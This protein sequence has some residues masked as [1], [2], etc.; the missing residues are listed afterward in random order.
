MAADSLLLMCVALII[1]IAFG[2]SA[3]YPLILRL[4]SIRH[5]C[6][7]PKESESTRSPAG[8]TDQA[9][10]S[11]LQA[12]PNSAPSMVPRETPE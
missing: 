4:L 1:A 12:K 11:P 10:S 3:V 8:T 6:M 9:A 2:A 7:E 5:G